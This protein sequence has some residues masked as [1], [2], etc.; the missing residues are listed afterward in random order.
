MIGEFYYSDSMIIKVEEYIKIAPN[1][2]AVNP[3]WEDKRLIAWTLV[4]NLKPIPISRR[5]LQ[6]FGFT[7]INP[8]WVLDINETTTCNIHIKDNNAC[9]VT[10]TMWG[11]EDVTISRECNYIHELQQF[12]K[13]LNLEF[14]FEK[15]LTI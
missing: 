14:D 10:L 7:Y 2:Y 6:V 11:V 8:D 1:T 5:L 4:S 3:Y 12:F 15:L 9:I 13:G